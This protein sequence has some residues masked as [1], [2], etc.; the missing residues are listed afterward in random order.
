MQ[1]ISGSMKVSDLQPEN[2]IVN[3]TDFQLAADNFVPSVSK[4]DMEYFN[5]LKTSFS[6]WWTLCN[7]RN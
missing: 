6:V 5:K 4:K 1:I 7:L 2:V 3:N